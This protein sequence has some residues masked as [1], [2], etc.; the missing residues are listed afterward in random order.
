MN[1][2]K[3]TFKRVSFYLLFL[4]LSGHL[5]S[6][7]PNTNVLLITI[8]TWRYDRVGIH[9][10]NLAKTPNLDRIAKLGTDFTR[11][12]AHNPTTLASHTN[13][14]TG[15]TPL[16]HGVADNDGFKLHET[17][18]TLAEHLK[19]FDYSTAAFIGSFIL[20]KL[21]GLSQGFDV[22]YEPIEKTDFIAEEV[23]QQALKWLMA[24]EG[25]WFCWIHLWDPHSPYTPPAPYDQQYRNDPY[26]GE[27]AYVDEQLGRVF[28]L[29]KRSGLFENS[30]VVITG[31]HGEGLGEHGEAEHGIFAY[32]STIHIP[33]IVLGK[34]FS[35]KIVHEAV[36]HIDIFPT[37]CD[38]LKIEHPDHLQGES[39]VPLLKK[40]K[41]INDSAI[42]F[43]SKGFYYHRGWAPLEGFISGNKKY[44]SLPI[45]ELYDLEKDSSETE[46]IISE[47]KISALNKRLSD[48]KNNL[49][50]KNKELSKRVLSLREI[51][52]LRSFGYL[53]GYKQEPKK[54]FTREDDPKVLLPIQNKLDKAKQFTKERKLDLAIKQAEEIIKERADFVGA[55]ILLSQIYQQQDQ[56]HKAIDVLEKG[57]RKRPDNIKMKSELGIALSETEQIERSIALLLEVLSVEEID[58]V[59]W[60][61]LGL[62][63]WKSGNFEEALRA[64]NK[65][66]ELDPNNA[67]IYGNLGNLYLTT[68]KYDLAEQ[69]FKK[70][71]E[72]SPK[73]AN[74]YNG[75]GAVYFQ[76][77][78]FDKAE[79]YFKK[80]IELSPSDYLAHYNLL[81]LYARKLN[82]ARKALKIY[83]AIKEK[84]YS[85]LPL[86]EREEIEKIKSEVMKK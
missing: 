46:N 47:V 6:K 78:K 51:K 9:D 20:G 2:G 49:K 14:L 37:V 36:S 63:Y 81:I 62:D 4:L 56:F 38:V 23:I 50:F 53:A 45:P 75:L 69:N 86:K 80:T 84:F 79:E 60:N 22:F 85:R 74:A 34:M 5:F 39:L 43:E 68:Q 24:Q 66:L 1:K 29:M 31:D 7:A 27:V 67:W 65:A 77:R 40:G 72:L 52:M 10:K 16:Y 73:L 48:F 35:Q 15:T 30:L 44:I 8:D 42:Y 17:F 83:R 11:A 54:A 18:L 26:S 32:N 55:Y 21:Y 12:F 58:P 64:Y 59:V 76:R 61:A 33:L 82:Q 3:S 25:R 41:K 19:P 28:S 70:A 57:L 13:I 71:I